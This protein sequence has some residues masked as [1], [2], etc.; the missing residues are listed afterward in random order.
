MVYLPRYLL[1]GYSTAL[2]NL[3]YTHVTYLR[4]SAKEKTQHDRRMWIL[5]TVYAQS[6]R[7]NKS[8]V[9]LC[10]KVRSDRACL[11]PRGR[12][13]TPGH[14]R[15]GPLLELYRPENTPQ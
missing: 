8:Q 13:S 5:L 10:I 1:L 9:Q 14:G 4:R 12:S 7:A 3:M 15:R 2:P 6:V 11:I